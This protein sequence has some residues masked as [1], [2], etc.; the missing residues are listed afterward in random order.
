VTS[1]VRSDAERAGAQLAGKYRLVRKLG[2]GGMGTVWEA[3][4]VAVERRVA[5]K[6]LLPELCAN[7][8]SRRRFEREA[9]A[10]GAIESEYV[11]S[12]FDY[13][14]SDAGEPFIVMEYLEGED[15][16]SLI[17][18]EGQLAVPRAAL[19]VLQALR[20]VQK[21][22]AKGIVHRDLKPQNL[23]VAR[24]DDGSELCKVLDFGVARREAPEPSFRTNAG[25]L[26]GTLGYMAPEQLRGEAVGVKADVYSLG[27]VLYECL[28]ACPP[29]EEG[30]PHELMYRVLEGQVARL[31]TR[32]ANLPAGLADVVHRALEVNASRRCEAREL[33]S[34][35]APYSE[36]AASS[37]TDSNPAARTLAGKSLLFGASDAPHGRQTRGR[38][39]ALVGLACTAGVILYAGMRL[40][41]AT[42]ETVGPSSSVLPAVR[43]MSA[44]SADK[45]AVRKEVPPVPDAA[46]RG[47]APPPSAAEAAS[48]RAHLPAS[49]SASRRLTRAAGEP[50]PAPSAIVPGARG[51]KFD[52]EAE[53]Y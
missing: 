8:K 11:V 5:V 18:R 20:G 48:V 50:N 43:R 17:A 52:F 15:L 42:P 34:M 30:K 37:R 32:R 46:V 29:F 28:A 25:Q 16:A 47:Q 22:H 14:V 31:E 2:E 13:G 4:H 19:L 23:F 35:L 12:A 49:G 36:R 27:C 51:A 10:A 7:D 9:K 53:P 21:A 40:R 44:A 45:Q 24:R 39:A 38:R 3:T 1:A 6:F 33:Q 41:E 26:V